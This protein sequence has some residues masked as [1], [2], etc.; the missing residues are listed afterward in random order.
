MR[1][2]G[3]FM[4]ALLAGAAGLGATPVRI[5][6]LGDSLTAQ[7]EARQ[8]LKEKLTA[9]GFSFEFV[10][11]QGGPELRH[12]G[13]SGYTIG[14]DTSKPGSL[15][16]N[17]ATWIPDAK[18]DVILLLIGN[19]DYN[20]KAGSL[21]ETAPE[22]L[23]T[24]LERI[25]D[26]APHATVIVSTVLKIAAVEDYAGALNRTIPETVAKLRAAGRQ[27]EFADLH[28]EVD[29]IKGSQPNN[30]P[31]SDFVDGTHLNSKG[32]RK[33]AD[34]WF[35]HLKPVLEARAGITATAAE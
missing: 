1:A 12:E 6:P 3:T 7:G 24:L 30:G 31:D 29:L 10:G 25:C 9:A 5:M 11:S 14:P 4:L 21:P 2:F 16:D 18:P 23:A 34:G 20:T 8:F 19:N 17:I 22:R 15:A 13:H 26:L 27:V 28:N 35:S 32:A 33:L